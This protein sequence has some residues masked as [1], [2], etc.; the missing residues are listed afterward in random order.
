MNR[1]ISFESS[2]YR[3]AKNERGRAGSFEGVAARNQ[4]GRNVTRPGHSVFVNNLPLQMDSHRLRGVF[5]RAGRISD[6][7]IPLKTGRKSNM[8]YGFIRFWQ[9]EDAVRS[10]VLF[11]SHLVRVNAL[12]LI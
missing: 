12:E 2:L 3:M 9:K 11:N 10:T 6:I 4:K 7:H 1:E 5:A 8:R